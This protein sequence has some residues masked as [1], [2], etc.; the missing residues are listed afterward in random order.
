MLHCP[1]APAAP[2]SLSASSLLELA[3][4]AEA[5]EKARGRF[6]LV[7]P[8]LDL[9]AV[10]DRLRH[11]VQDG[12]ARGR[13]RVAASRASLRPG[14]LAPAQAARALRFALSNF[15]QNRASGAPN[16][17]GPE[18]DLATVIEHAER[19][20]RAM[21]QA[22]AGRRFRL[23]FQP[24]V[25]LGTRA[26]HHYEAL[27]RPVA[28]PGNPV[29]SPQEFVSFAEA[30]G[31]A[32]ALDTAVL[33]QACRVL[34][35]TGGPPVAIN[36]SGLSLQSPSFRA[37]VLD[38]L[39]KRPRGRLLFELTETAEIEDMPAAARSMAL[40]R[41]AGAPM[42]L[43]DF[44]AGAAA[45]RYLR[46]LPL[47]FVKIDGGYVHSALQSPRERGFVVS[48][49]DLARSVRARTVAEMVETERQADL[50]HELG[51]ELG[52]GWLFGRPAALPRLQD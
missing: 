22:I 38:L 50:L 14:R 5:A 8:D 43:D 4:S 27:L 6:G 32:E 19:R 51:A 12:P 10:V 49:I 15:A 13:T 52:Q 36:V 33:E 37:H 7:V 23:L 21:Q 16:S 26:I 20:A 46:N 30:V 24:I 3:G 40:F 28:T 35:R 45:F 44:G 31:L 29:Q 2:D 41:E 25:T 17:G 47:D 9:E 39:Q 42:C 11:L 48:M 1:E 34:D 18:G